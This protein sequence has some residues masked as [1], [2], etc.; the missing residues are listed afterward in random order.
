MYPLWN[1]PIFRN[2]GIGLVF[3]LMSPTL[4][5]AA[6]PGIFHAFTEHISKQI[7][8][9]VSDFT[10]AQTCT[11]WFYRKLR[12]APYEKPA[13]ERIAMR[14]GDPEAQEH[15]CATRYPNG[16]DGARERFSETQSALSLSLTFYQFVLI[17]DKN[18]DEQYNA[19]ELEDVLAS[20]GLVYQSAGEPL[21]QLTQ[22]FDA[23]RQSNQFEVL[24][25]GMQQLFQKGYRLTD[26]DQGQMDRITGGNSH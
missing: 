16:I 9:D 1:M 15:L 25:D 12:K 21:R 26:F 11:E 5:L 13:V 14:V 23:V 19:A 20:V 18:D 17:A 10:E 24:T 4:S 2:A 6:E 8:K 22:K 3:Y 7:T